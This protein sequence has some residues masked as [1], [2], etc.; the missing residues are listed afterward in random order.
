MIKDGRQVAPT[1][2]G[3]RD[4]HVNRYSLALQVA[5]NEQAATAVDLGAGIGYGAWM[6]ATAGLQVT[7]IERDDSALEYGAQHYGHGGL[8]R[9]K[10]DVLDADIPGCDILTAFEVV[11]HVAGIQSVLTRASTRARW[12]V[13]SVPNEDVIP[14]AQNK[15]HEHVRHYT[16]DQFREMLEDC[17]WKVT[18]MLSQAGKT[19][20]DAAVTPGTTGRTLVCVARSRWM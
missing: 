1:L 17:D 8:T 9:V 18:A 3:I 7:A 11:E 12:L 13:C 15:H 19:G 6:L 5:T 10:G 20:A 2:A 4:D 14:F 16:A